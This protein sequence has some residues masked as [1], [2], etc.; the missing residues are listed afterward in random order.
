MLKKCH[1]RPYEAPTIIKVELD[2][3]VS[4]TLASVGGGSGPPNPPF[5]ILEFDQEIE[6]FSPIE[7]LIL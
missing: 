4:L 5:G 3:E 7:P 2:N 1:S 6:L